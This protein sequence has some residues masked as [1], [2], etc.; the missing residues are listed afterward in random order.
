LPR[1]SRR[2]R[3]PGRLL[4]ARL[5]SRPNWLATWLRRPVHI[6]SHWPDLVRN[7]AR[8]REIPRFTN[9]STRSDGAGNRATYAETNRAERTARGARAASQVVGCH[10]SAQIRM[11]R[12]AETVTAA[13]DSSREFIMQ[14]WIARDRGSNA[15]GTNG[16]LF[17][18]VRQGQVNGPGDQSRARSSRELPVSST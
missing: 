3:V 2:P 14:E 13:S 8:A 5:K 6:S 17:D 1:A 4:R 12:L 18:L 10:N 11:N 16:G 15:H 7:A 9:R